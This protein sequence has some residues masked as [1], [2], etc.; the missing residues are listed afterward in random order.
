MVAAIR[1]LLSCLHHLVPSP[2]WCMGILPQQHSFTRLL[3][4]HHEA[5]VGPD[6]E[7][8]TVP[9]EGGS[10]IWCVST[11]PK[12]GTLC[13]SPGHWMKPCGNMNPNRVPVH[14]QLSTRPWATDTYSLSPVVKLF[15]SSVFAQPTLLQHAHQNGVKNL[16]KVKVGYICHFLLSL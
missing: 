14:C 13:Y 12:L 15:F 2:P 9:L 7:F 16:T 4:E 6:V 11:S 5:F 1:L 10:T 3:G 8:I